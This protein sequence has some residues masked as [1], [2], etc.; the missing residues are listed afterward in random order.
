MK[1]FILS[2]LLGITLTSCGI[3]HDDPCFVVAPLEKVDFQK[4][5]QP[6]D[7]VEFDTLPNLKGSHVIRFDAQY[8]MRKGKGDCDGFSPE[9]PIDELKTRAYFSDTVYF[10]DNKTPIL[11]NTDI[12]GGTYKG[13]VH[14]W[15]DGRR[16]FPIGENRLN[17]FGGVTYK[18]VMYD[19]K[20]VFVT[21]E[22]QEFSDSIKVY[23][24]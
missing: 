14:L 23:F 4:F 2:L 10:G 24:R 1:L 20:F 12:N 16:S 18:P 5:S 21:E 8:D 11:P 17:I 9:T 19:V 13:I 22:G 6:G 3:V 7:T 15:L